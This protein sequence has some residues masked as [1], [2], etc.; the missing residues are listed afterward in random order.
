M[1]KVGLRTMMVVVAILGVAAY[2]ETLRRKRAGYLMK[3]QF[4]VAEENDNATRE[5]LSRSSLS[6]IQEIVRLVQ[7][8]NHSI[9]DD[10]RRRDGESSDEYRKLKEI[11]EQ[12]LNELRAQEAAQMEDLRSYAA[13]R[14]YYAEMH[15]KYRRAARYPWLPVA[16]DPPDPQANDRVFVRRR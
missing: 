3:V 1:P 16:P 15:N 7:N 11:I 12:D 10:A 13:S 9:L 2:G 8:S 4:A 14:R 6:H 5:A